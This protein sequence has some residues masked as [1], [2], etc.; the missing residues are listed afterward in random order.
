[1]IEAK[2]S[3]RRY[4]TKAQIIKVFKP[5][6]SIKLIEIEEDRCEAI[7]W[8][9]EMRAKARRF[10]IKLA[11]VELRKDHHPSFFK[12]RICNVPAS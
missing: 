2:Q 10:D 1:M 11:D 8:N 6:E 4:F 3:K 9:E 7:C 5:F 12:L